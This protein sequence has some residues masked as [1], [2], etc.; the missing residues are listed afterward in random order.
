MSP[1]QRG[2][3]PTVTP[4]NREEKKM[5]QAC[6]DDYL[7]RVKRDKLIKHPDVSSDYRD[8]NIVKI[9][10]NDETNDTVHSYLACRPPPK[11]QDVC[12]YFS[13]CGQKPRGFIAVPYTSS[14]PNGELGN[15]ASHTT[16]LSTFPKGELF[17]LK[18]SWRA[19]FTESEPTLLAYL[20]SK[21]VPNLPDVRH[22]GDVCFKTVT[23]ETLNDTLRSDP[24]AKSWKSRN[25]I[26]HHM[27]HCRIVTKLLIPLGSVRDAQE[28]LSV[29]RDV[30]LSK[31]LWIACSG[32]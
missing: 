7:E 16:T 20:K 15:D 29:G 13:P 8:K 1:V 6:V 30:L 23:Q 25:N 10:V 17:W 3:D 4:A 32:I 14:I 27:L 19:D 31:Y 24:S 21:K 28:L 18:D 12:A 26:I 5:F 9:Q 2:F 22:G 11:K